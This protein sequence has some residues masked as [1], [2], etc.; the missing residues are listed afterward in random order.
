ME[1]QDDGSGGKVQMEALPPLLVRSDIRGPEGRQAPCLW[2]PKTERHIAQ[3]FD[4]HILP[5]I[6]LLWLLAFLDRSN[7]GRLAMF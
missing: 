3:K 5:W 1:A 7:I 6:F 4:L 2:A